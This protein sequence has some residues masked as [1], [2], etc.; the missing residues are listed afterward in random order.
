[1]GL[2]I[3]R[4]G[5]WLEHSI[6]STHKKEQ[7]NEKVLTNHITKE[8]WIDILKNSNLIGLRAYKQQ[9]PTQAYQMEGSAM[10]DEMI[11][12]IKIRCV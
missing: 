7:F 11:N 10:F 1:M 12:N 9:D 8:Q 6:V 5:S 2:H 4:V 3:L